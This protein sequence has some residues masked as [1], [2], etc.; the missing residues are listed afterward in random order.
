MT[1]NPEEFIKPRTEKPAEIG[2]DTVF[3][4]FMCQDCNEHVRQAKFN[5]D[6]LLIVYTCSQNHRNEVQL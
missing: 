5:E 2:V 4:T 3:G 1:I 6:D